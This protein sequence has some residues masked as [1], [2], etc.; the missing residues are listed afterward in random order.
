MNEQALEEYIVLVF[1]VGAYNFCVPALEVDSIIKKPA[2]EITPVP[3][4]PEA[5]AGV[6]AHRGQIAT[7]INLHRKFGLP[8]PV[9]RSSVMMIAAQ[10]KDDLVAFCVDDV[11]DVFSSEEIEWHPVTVNTSFTAVDKLG[12]HDK[13]FVM[14]TH[15]EA[16]SMMKDCE[17]SDPLFLNFAEAHG[18]KPLPDEIIAPD[19]D[20]TD[21]QKEE[22]PEKDIKTKTAIEEPVKQHSKPESELPEKKTVLKDL[23]KKDKQIQKPSAVA[24]HSSTRA[25]VTR[26]AT[27]PDRKKTPGTQ[28]LKRTETPETQNADTFKSSSTGIIESAVK[29]PD[30]RRPSL[31]SDV[32]E[33]EKKKSRSKFKWIAAGII[34][35]VLSAIFFLIS[36]S[37]DE[38]SRDTSYV[39]STQVYEENSTSSYTDTAEPDAETTPPEPE[40]VTEKPEKTAQPEQEIKVTEVSAISTPDT[41]T[42]PDPEKTEH[43]SDA[44]TEE[45]SDTHQVLLKVETSD[46]TLT[47]ERPTNTNSPPALPDEPAVQNDSPA[48]VVKSGATQEEIV[49]IVIKG[50]TLWDIAETYLGNPWRYPEL[51]DLSQI[52][53]PHWI[54]PGDVIRIIRRNLPDTTT[55]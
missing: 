50:D 31:V 48:P 51:A 41:S 33:P 18:I 37:P 36:E 24:A 6:L 11:S 25:P 22:Q 8:E 28:P 35:L 29:Q 16:L 27:S 43:T 47:V 17:P 9:N 52:K 13:L 3:T 38:K 23:N 2:S 26:V 5:V 46:F 7:V 34:A 39:K 54:Y 14:H 1:R 10:I 12:I 21:E 49:H 4:A 15:L 42:A 53:D 40:P 19:A 20:L 55:N 30:D 32:S 44:K 45:S